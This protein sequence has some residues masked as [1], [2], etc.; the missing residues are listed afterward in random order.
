MRNKAV[1]VGY[2][3]EVARIASQR[4]LKDA[5]FFIAFNIKK[6]RIEEHAS[7]VLKISHMGASDEEI[8]EAIAASNKLEADC[9]AIPHDLPDDGDKAHSALQKV[10]EGNPGFMA[11][12][13]GLLEDYIRKRQSGIALSADVSPEENLITSRDWSDIP[14]FKKPLFLVVAFLVFMPGYLILIWSGDTYYRKN[15]VV[16]RTSTKRKRLMTMIVVLLIVSSS[17]KFFG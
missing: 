5:A 10:K 13:Y 17:L 4:P 1:E 12:T 3:T 9:L 2:I 7:D 11:E 14:Y 15:G 6:R 16:Y 8:K